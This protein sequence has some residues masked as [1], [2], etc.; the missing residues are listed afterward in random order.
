MII[1]KKSYT[2]FRMV[3]QKYI[4]GP[5]RNIYCGI[6]IRQRKIQDREGVDGH[7]QSMKHHPVAYQIGEASQHTQLCLRKGY[8]GEPDNSHNRSKRATP[9]VFRHERS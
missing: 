9:H 1:H 4:L 8:E 5:Y 6:H 2:F 3:I 7:T